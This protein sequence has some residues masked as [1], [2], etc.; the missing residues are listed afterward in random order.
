MRK[1]IFF[2]STLSILFSASSEK[3]FKIDGMTCG[4][5]ANKVQKAL[6]GLDGVE[7]CS[8]NVDKG[9]ALIAF[10]DE[11]VNEEQI[12]STLTDKTN[13]SCSIPKKKVRKGF[14]QRL[15]GW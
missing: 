13:F 15:F 14:F 9:Q 8:V 10:D 4:G 7:S 5:C 2:L 3:T 1:I 6:D 11:K 12:L